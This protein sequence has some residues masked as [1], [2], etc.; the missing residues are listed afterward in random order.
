MLNIHHSLDNKFA[1]IELAENKALIQFSNNGKFLCAAYQGKLELDLTWKFGVLETETMSFVPVVLNSNISQI[2]DICFSPDEMTVLISGATE[3]E[4]TEILQWNDLKTGN[5][6][7]I[8]CSRYGSVVY[9][10]GTNLIIRNFKEKQCQV[11]C[12]DGQALDAS[13]PP[14]T[15]FSPDGELFV[16]KDHILRFSVGDYPNFRLL[17]IAHADFV[18]YY[19][20]KIFTVYCSEG[21]IYRNDK[22]LL[23]GIPIDNSEEVS[24]FIAMYSFR[25]ETVTLVD[26]KTEE[27]YTLSISDFNEKHVVIMP[28]QV[29]HN[30]LDGMS[31]LP[32]PW[33][34]V[35]SEILV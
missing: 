13:L 26:M 3:D 35:L 11:V 34:F 33:K 24:H 10:V 20:E 6:I 16:N 28:T 23:Q 25:G 27:I 30:L 32:H 21:S 19:N 17:K 8:S 5:T 1:V 15:S 12:R 22:L 14:R 18:H 7:Y 9:H 31:V 2:L 29:L 4:M